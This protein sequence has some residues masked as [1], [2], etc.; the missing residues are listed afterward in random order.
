MGHDELLKFAQSEDMGVL[1]EV[2]YRLHRA[3]VR[4][5]V[6]LIALTVGLI[7]LTAALVYFAWHH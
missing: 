6:V 4:L 1:V 5:N 2:S 3:T 7:A